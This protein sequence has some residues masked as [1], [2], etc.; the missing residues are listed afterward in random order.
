MNSGKTYIK[1]SISQS[2]KKITFKKY[3]N[4]ERRKGRSISLMGKLH[5]TQKFT[6]KFTQHT[7]KSLV[8]KHNTRCF[9]CTI[10]NNIVFPYYKIRWT[11]SGLI[12][13]RTNFGNLFGLFLCYRGRNV[14]SSKYGEFLG[15]IPVHKMSTESRKN[16]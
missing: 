12:T 10:I 16:V 15:T 8:I 13:P 14:T 9:E 1:E 2:L 3:L 4:Q 5:A 11:G 7:K 6:Q